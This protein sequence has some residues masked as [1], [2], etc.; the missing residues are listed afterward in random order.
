V[1]TSDQC[2]KLLEDYK[3]FMVSIKHA[4]GYTK[5][6]SPPLMS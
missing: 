4:N 6:A 1:L 3:T 5:R 2:D